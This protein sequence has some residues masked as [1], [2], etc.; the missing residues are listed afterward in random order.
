MIFV[1][2]MEPE[3]V[4]LYPEARRQFPW[5]YESNPNPDNLRK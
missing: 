5:P 1:T 3:Y 4:V 2:F